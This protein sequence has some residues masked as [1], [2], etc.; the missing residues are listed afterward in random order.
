MLTGTPA[1]TQLASYKTPR[2]LVV[3]QEIPRTASGKILRHRLRADLDS[4][5]RFAG[6]GLLGPDH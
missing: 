5:G 3:V 6:H 1:R 2:R 4:S